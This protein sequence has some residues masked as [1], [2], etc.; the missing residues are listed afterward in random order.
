MCR[1]EELTSTMSPLTNV[2]GQELMK[3]ISIQWR[4]LTLAL[5]YLFTYTLYWVCIKVLLFMRIKWLTR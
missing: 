4:A 3:A 5:I 2:T 1:N